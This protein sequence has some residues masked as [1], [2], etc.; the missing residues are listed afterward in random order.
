[1][2]NNVLSNL[3]WRIESLKRKI[4][5]IVQTLMGEERYDDLRMKRIDQCADKAAL[6]NRR[7]NVIF[8]DLH[9]GKRCFILGNGPS[10]RSVNMKSLENEYVFSVNNFS[11]VPDCEEAKT[12]FH[13]WAD[14]SFFC[15]RDDQKYKLDELLDNYDRIAK[16]SPICFLPDQ[17]VSFVTKYELNK[18]LDIHYF[19]CFD[20]VD[21]KKNIYYDLTKQV[22]SFA[23]VV[24]YAIIIAIYMGFTEI[25]L[26]G[27]DS[28]NIVSVLNCAMNISNKN[29]HAY[30]NDDVDERYRELLKHWN[31]SDVFHDQYILFLGY[32]KLYEE[33]RKKNIKLVNCSSSTIIN[34]IPRKKLEEVL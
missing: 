12:N 10:L 2:K 5:N 6:N 14:L 19:S 22:T 26:L 13:L 34:E 17:A 30:D 4:L 28:T 29:M 9:S 23:T 32:K 3:I 15:M 8:K 25:Y 27:C 20:I 16:M 1:M 18:K 7:E 21:E 11:S 31:M 33:C 24:Q